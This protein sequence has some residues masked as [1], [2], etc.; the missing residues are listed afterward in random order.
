MISMA[1]VLLDEQCINSVQEVLRSGQ[2][3]QGTK[4]AEFERLFANY[5]GT[6][7]AIA[8]NSGTAALHV[9]LISAGLGQGDEV[10]T[11]PFSFV[12]TAN[13]CLYCNSKP[14]FVD[15]DPRTYNIRPDLIEK[16]ITPK[17]R[18]IIIVHLYGQSCDLNEIADICRKY[19]L[20]LIED[21]CQAHGALYN[22]RKVGSFGIGCFSFYPTKN[23]TTS[24]GGMITT[25][26]DLVA[27]K[28]IL[29]RQHGQ[30]QRY[31]HDVLGYNFR[32][33]DIS[34]AIGISQLRNLDAANTRRFHN[35][36]YLSDY[37]QKYV[38]GLVTPYIAPNRNHVFHQYTV[39]VTRNYKLSREKLIQKL[40][41]RQIGSSIHYPVPIH[42][43]KLY[44]NLGYSIQLPAAEI[45]SEE[46]LSLPVHPGLNESDLYTIAEALKDE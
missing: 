36:D 25:D 26:D 5:I 40:A 13:C 22:N 11:T 46:V 21:A 6:K 10:I 3:A 9:A 29:I 7:H 14:V 18:A 16:S 43:Q 34:A 31:V 28:A 15:I 45:A 17:T 20:I 37:L 32:M 33:T 12:A 1:N 19:S 2:L 35:A 4:V 30:S 44:Q 39:R 41:D 23:M 24:E 42:K 8:V 27:Q 38:P